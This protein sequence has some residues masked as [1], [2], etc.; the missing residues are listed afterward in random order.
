MTTFADSILS[1]V[2]R[3][4]VVSSIIVSAATLSNCGRSQPPPPPLV[5]SPSSLPNLSTGDPVQLPLSVNGGVAPYNWSL[6]SGSLPHG[7]KLTPN[8]PGAVIS[9]TP[10]TAAQGATFAVRVTDSAGGSGSQQYTVSVLIGADSLT[11]SPSV[12]NFGPQLLTTLSGSQTVTVT[13]AIL[14]PIAISNVAIV[15]DIYDFGSNQTCLTTL[16][17]GASCTLSEIFIPTQVGPRTA[18]IT[19]TDD[20][21][22]SPHS[23]SLNG[24]GVVSGANATLSATGIS[25]GTVAVNTTSPPKSVTLNNYGTAA[26]NISAITASPPFAET[27]NCVPTVASNGGCTINVTVTPTASGSISGTLSIAD[28]AN[29]SPQTISLTGSAITTEDALTGYCVYEVPV[30]GCLAV[31]VDPQD[32]RVGAPAQS[33]FS[34]DDCEG[35]KVVSTRGCRRSISGHYQGSCQAIAGAAH[36]EP[37]NK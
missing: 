19:L 34:V 11:L 30:T 3:L 29:G 20:T 26:L 18:T 36:Q 35:S 31:V 1:R 9:G 13:N 8:P 24:T 14:S 37:A 2:G 15:G 6:S 22:G 21:Q 32:C 10:D 4:A 12:L 28:N 16:A 17:A 23:V 7:L 25:F 5:V 27:D 33:V